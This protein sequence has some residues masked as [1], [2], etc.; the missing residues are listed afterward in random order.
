M[1]AVVGKVM[2]RPMGPYSPNTVYDILDIVTFNDRAWMCKQS[3]TMGILPNDDNSLYWMLLISSAVSDASTLDGYDSTYFASQASIDALVNGTTAAGNAT[4]L[5][6]Y[7]SEHFATKES[8]DAI[9]DGTTT[10][11]SAT[12]ATTLD[13]HEAAYF[14]TK[15]ELAEVTNATTLEGHP[16]EYFATQEA[17]TTAIAMTEGVIADVVDGTTPVANASALAGHEAAYFATQEAMTAVEAE[18][19]SLLD[20]TALPSHLHSA[21]NIT[22]GTFVGQVVADA[23]ATADLTV[24]QVRNIYAGTEELEAGVSTL[25]TG[26]LY[27]QYE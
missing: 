22:A 24:A 26:V 25:P 15:D 20:G 23:T 7:E 21:S 6:G 14:A 13:G 10:V 17:L 19:D 27:I 12:N 5:A 11:P 18:V 1:G 4:K 16:A 2:P 9:V 8:V 3:G